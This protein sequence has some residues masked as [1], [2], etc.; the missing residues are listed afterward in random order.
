MI[1]KQKVAE[2]ASQMSSQEI[3]EEIN[4]WNDSTKYWQEVLNYA[5]LSIA[6]DAIANNLETKEV[7]SQEL[8]K[9]LDV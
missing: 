3:L 7:L 9:K 8:C 4:Y 6:K 5:D 2:I 1:D